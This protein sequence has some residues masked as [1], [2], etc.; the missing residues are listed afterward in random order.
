MKCHKTT[1]ASVPSAKPPKAPDHVLPGEMSG[2]NF[3][4]PTCLP[5]KKAPVSVSQITLPRNTPAQIPSD[6]V[7]RAERMAITTMPK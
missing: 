7:P 6:S 3:S 4:P 1:P 5:V 2:A